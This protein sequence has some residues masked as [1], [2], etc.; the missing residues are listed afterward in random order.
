MLRLT[1]LA[2]RKQKPS[3][4]KLRSGQRRSADGLK[5][6]K[7]CTVRSRSCSRTTSN[8]VEKKPLT[9]STLCIPVNAAA[10]RVPDTTIVPYETSLM[11]AIKDLLDDAVELARKIPLPAEF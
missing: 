9:G 2:N 6:L 5:K 8:H 1:W 3:A 4:R 7:R 11:W 10:K